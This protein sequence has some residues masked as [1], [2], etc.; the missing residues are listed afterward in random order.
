MTS[1]N[2]LFIR[3]TS[4][5]FLSHIRSKFNFWRLKCGLML[6]LSR[7]V[8]TVFF[9]YCSV[10]SCDNLYAIYFAL[11]IWSFLRQKKVNPISRNSTCN[12]N[13]TIMKKKSFIIIKDTKIISSQIS[14]YT[15]SWNGLLY[16]KLELCFYNFLLNIN[17]KVL[18][19]FWCIA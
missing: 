2:W 10:E 11:I 18:C 16:V 17:K 19:F 12:N 7:H 3:S 15:K 4:K 1:S 6:C 14:P 8:A 13:L 9:I 5:N